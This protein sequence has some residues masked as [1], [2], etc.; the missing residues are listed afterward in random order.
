MLDE[1]SIIELLSIEEEED[2]LLEEDEELEEDGLLIE[3]EALEELE[4]SELVV[5]STGRLCL[6]ERKYFAIPVHIASA[7][8]LFT[9]A[10]AIPG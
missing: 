5:S 10:L 1:D 9:E 6:I 4:L 8:I 7:F 2:E 3:D